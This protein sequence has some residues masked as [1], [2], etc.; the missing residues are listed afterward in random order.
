MTRLLIALVAAL[1]A[2]VALAS[3]GGAREAGASFACPGDTSRQPI[4]KIYGANR[5]STYCNDGATATATV[6]GKKLPSFVGG[7]CWRDKSRTTYVNIG[8]ETSY[9][10]RLS[11]P[12]GFSLSDVKPGGVLKDTVSLGRGTLT[13][14]SAPVKITWNANRRSGTWSGK[15][16][17]LAGGK[18][19]YVGGSGTFACRR[20]LEVPL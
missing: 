4:G 5:G 6:A 20:F 15:W 16:P 18:L 1:V 19:T 2:A 10:R 3:P 13:W 12:A 9:K 11:D 8:M 17:T 7:V 14:G